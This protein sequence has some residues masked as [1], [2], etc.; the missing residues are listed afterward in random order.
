MAAAQRNRAIAHVSDLV[1]STCHKSYQLASTPFLGTHLW[2]SVISANTEERRVS[3]VDTRGTHPWHSVISANT[4]ERAQATSLERSPIAV[5]SSTS[6]TRALLTYSI[7]STRLEESGQC[8]V[9]TWVY[10]TSRV[11]ARLA[12]SGQRTCCTVRT[13]RV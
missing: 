9:G 13:L 12:Q 5:S 8:T 11:S 2:R 7:V 6:F 1:S 3:H 10:H 4:E